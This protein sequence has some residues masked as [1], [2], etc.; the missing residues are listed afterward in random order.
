MKANR[1]R[2]ARF[3]GIGQVK[4]DKVKIMQTQRIIDILEHLENLPTLPVIVQ[5]IQRMLSNPR[6]NLAQVAAIITKDQAIST[7]VIRL[8]N[9]AFYG[10]PNKI[11]SIQRAIVVLGLNTVKNIVVGV[12]VVKIFDGLPGAFTFNREQFWLHTFGCALGSKLI[13]EHLG[14]PEPEDYFLAGLLHD[15]GILVIDQYLHNDFVRVLELV[16]DRKIDYVQAEQN[17]LG[18]AHTDVG[19]YMA[20]RWK[21]PDF[22]RYTIKYH[23]EPMVI[24]KKADAFRD[25]LTIVHL[26]D[27]KTRNME[28]MHFLDN[29]SFSYEERA[30]N[31]LHL[32]ESVLEEIFSVVENETGKLVKE[33]GL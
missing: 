29:F 17:I 20:R 2:L 24:N 33:W 28:S 30:F 12:S 1:L 27:A 14:R 3:A 4:G 16:K 6:S 21:M 10:F 25:Y 9:S 18:C 31:Y 19:E 13:A 7:R 8:V 11:G 22:M 23:H 5:Q 26:A 15:I 32:N